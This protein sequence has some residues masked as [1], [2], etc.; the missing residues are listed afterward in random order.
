MPGTTLE[1]AA[2]DLIILYVHA[3]DDPAGVVP[4]IRQAVKTVEPDLALVDVNTLAAQLDQSVGDERSTAAL[5]GCLGGLSLL[6]ASIGLFGTMSHSVASRTKELGIRMSLGADRTIVRTMMLR[7]ALIV[8]GAGLAVGL[9]VSLAGTR[10]VSKLLF[11]GT[12]ADPL[13][14]ITAVVAL[15]LV[16]LAA[17]YLPAR[18]A[19]GIDPIAALKVD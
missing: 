2:E 16:T 4:T 3:T 7:E 8:V 14:M 9:P 18:R 15:M 12:R 10:L 1:Q 17:A 19:A 13:V 5:L 11:G 6:L